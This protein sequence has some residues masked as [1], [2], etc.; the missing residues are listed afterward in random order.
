MEDVLNREPGAALS[1]WHN[2]YGPIVRFFGFAGEIR[3][4]IT[5]P[6]A[7]TSILLRNAYS[8]H[9]GAGNILADILGHGLICAEGM[10]RSRLS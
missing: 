1:D 6:A 2:S 9:N 5:D 4:S 7:L 3:L 8:F 10:S